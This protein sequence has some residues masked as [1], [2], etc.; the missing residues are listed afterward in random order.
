MGL[1]KRDIRHNIKRCLN[2]LTLKADKIPIDDTPM[3]VRLFGKESVESRRF[4][5]IAA[6]GHFDFG[7]GIHHPCWTNVDVDRSWKRSTLY[8]KGVEFNLKKDI[9]HDLLSL[10]PIPVVT[11]SMELVHSRLAIEHIT[12]EAARIMFEEVHRMLKDGGLFRVVAPNIDLDY[13]AY[14]LNDLNFF[15]WFPENT[16]IEQRFIY[17]F[18]ATVSEI[19]PDGDDER[20]SVQQ[21]RD[22]LNT[23]SLPDAL[24]YCTA[25]CSIDLQKKHRHNHMNWWNPAKL[26]RMLTEAGFTSVY[27]S[28]AGQSRSPVLRNPAHFDNWFRVRSYGKHMM[29]M[30]AVK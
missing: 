21:F 9:A 18:A 7:C 23:M 2:Y 25:R 6:G 1:L 27:L 29:Y 30:E 12:D 22:L 17:H 14:L 19:F 3:Y 15:D 8:P 13:N 20:V 10:K 16:P 28:A 26:E 24:N 11:R 4:C 5:N